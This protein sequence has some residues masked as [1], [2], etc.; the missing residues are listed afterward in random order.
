MSLLVTAKV[1]NTI[2]PSSAKSILLPIGDFADDNGFA[3]PS[4][5]T[6]SFKSSV[7][8]TALL[9]HL[10]TLENLKLIKR[11]KRYADNSNKRHTSTAYLINIKELDKYTFEYKNLNK[12]DLAKLERKIIEVGNKYQKEYQDVRNYESEKEKENQKVHNVNNLN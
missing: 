7:K 5:R 10:K 3:F 11:T 8:K 12:E 6:L 1:L 4:I 2:L 9:Y